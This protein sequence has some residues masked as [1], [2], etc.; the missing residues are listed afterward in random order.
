[1]EKIDKPYLQV[2]ANCKSG[3]NRML[4]RRGIYIISQSQIRI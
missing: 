2:D 4:L 3:T 1:M